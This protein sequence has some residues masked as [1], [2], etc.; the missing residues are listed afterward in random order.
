LEIEDEE[1]SRELTSGSPPTLDA[2]AAANRVA[3]LAEAAVNDAKAEAAAAESGIDKPL[4]HDA[5][6][7]R[8]Q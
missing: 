3:E 6:R 8:F 1:G 5:R 2:A 7:Q 4:D